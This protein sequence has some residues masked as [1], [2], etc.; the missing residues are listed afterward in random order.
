MWQNHTLLFDRLKAHDELIT[1]L[2]LL[3]LMAV[4]FL[5]YTFTILGDFYHDNVS[6]AINVALF[7]VI[8]AVQG[9]MLV[10]THGQ[11]RLLRDAFVQRRIL[12]RRRRQPYKL[13]HD[14]AIA[15]RILV[16]PAIFLVAYLL[17]FAH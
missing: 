10:Y 17:S 11:P 4:S 2:N 6:L 15:A 1:W 3:L 16:M 7:F 14:L 12:T 13:W 9:A 5:P 8:A